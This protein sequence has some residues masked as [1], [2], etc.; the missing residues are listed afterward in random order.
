MTA[1][2]SSRA[3]WTTEE[4]ALERARRDLRERGVDVAD[5]TVSNP[6]RVGL[7]VL[8]TLRGVLDGTAGAPYAPEPLGPVSTRTAIAAHVLAAEG[9]ALDP[10]AMFLSASTSEAY[11]WIFKLLCDPGDDVLVPAPSYPLFGWLSALEGVATRTYPLVREERFRVDLAELEASIGPRTRAIVTV[12]PNNPTG[13]FV[14]PDDADAIDRVAS[15]HGIAVV[16][17]EVFRTFPLDAP[18]GRASFARPRA[19][20]TFVLDGLSKRCAAPGL[21]LAFTACFGPTEAVH[22]ALARIEIIADTYLSVATPITLAIGAVL[23]AE[24]PIRAAVDARLRRNLAA[25]DRALATRGAAL[26]ISRNRVEGGWSVVVEAPRTESD[27]DR[28]LRA[29]RDHHVLVHP[30]FFFEMDREGSFV[31]SLL[32]DTH[33]FDVGIDRLIDAIE[34]GP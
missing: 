4:N 26:G 9:I 11:A 28:A 13:S 23:G 24:A 7:D 10:E 34:V 15:A 2:F 8:G 12:N 29:L 6:T 20:L 14:H 32:S 1:R 33:R 25:L 21:K 5:L 16:A 31:L 18:A 3:R 30:G 17:D 27:G 19:A 22:A